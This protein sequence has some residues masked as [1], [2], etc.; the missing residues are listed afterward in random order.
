MRRLLLLCVLALI[1]AP[2][3]QAHEVGLSYAATNCP[4]INYQVDGSG[5]HLYYDAPHPDHIW[6]TNGV[7]CETG[8]NWFYDDEIYGKDGKDELYGLDGFDALWGG[9]GAD[10]LRGG[11][12]NDQIWGGPGN[13]TIYCGSGNNDHAY[14]GTGVD[15]YSGCEN[16]G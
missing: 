10:V 7:S 6:G 8:S 11:A 9:D 1:A 16:T 3:A 13:D 2:T 4:P 5:S 12:H 14:G 15:I